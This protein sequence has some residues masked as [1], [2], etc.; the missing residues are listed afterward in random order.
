MVFLWGCEF[1]LFNSLSMSN[2]LYHWIFLHLSFINSLSS[3]FLG[4]LWRTGVFLDTV[5]EL[6]LVAKTN[7][8]VNAS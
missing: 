8:C 7:S 1:R 3:D 5:H 4:N 6:S 2:N